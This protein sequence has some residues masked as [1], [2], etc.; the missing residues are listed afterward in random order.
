[1]RKQVRIL[2]ADDQAVNRK[3]TMRQLE[4]LGVSVDVAV[5]GREALE[6]VLRTP[7]DL[8]F[9]DCHMPEMDGLHA[10]REIRKAG[11]RTPVIGFTASLGELDRDQCLAAGMD[12]YMVKPVSQAELHRVLGQW[13]TDAPP[14]DASTISVLQQIDDRLLREVI[15]IYVSEAPKRIASIRD[16]ISKRDPQLLAAAAHALRSSSGNVGASRVRE[17]CAELE[18][19]GRSGEIT[20]APKLVEELVAEYERAVL[21]LGELHQA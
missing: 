13:L 8:I 20:G 7:Y 11:K 19:I 14:I 4:K 9:M 12:D 10:T 16:A 1:M 5:N 21:A 15:D 6:A 3:L 17:I 18:K 2:V